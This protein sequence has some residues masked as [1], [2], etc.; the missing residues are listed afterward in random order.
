MRV[1]QKRYTFLNESRYNL[2]FLISIFIFIILYLFIAFVFHP[3]FE[4]TDGFSYC[5]YF[6]DILNSNIPPDHSEYWPAGLPLL[7][8]GFSILI[9]I[10]NIVFDFS[11]CNN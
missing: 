11:F 3:I 10:F 2:A 7:I 4:E 9:C 8:G 1:I 5:V 6:K